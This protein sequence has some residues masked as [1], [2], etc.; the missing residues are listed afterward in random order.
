M[1][2]KGPDRIQVH[3][4]DRRR[5]RPNLAHIMNWINIHTDTL[6]S[7]DYLGA[8]PVERAT[9]LNLIG[10]CCSQEN[11]G[12]IENAADWSDRKW[13]QLCGV[14]KE[15]ATLVSALYQLGTNGDLVVSLYPISK[16][17]EVIAKR[18]TAKLNGAK[19]GRPPKETKKEPTPVIL[20]NP[21]H[22]PNVT[23]GESGREGKGREE[24]G[25]EGISC[26][27][28]DAEKS[29]L[30]EFWKQCPAQSRTRSTKRKVSDAWKRI[31]QGQRPD[32]ETF[33]GAIKQ[34]S[35]SED[36]TKD[37]GQF[38]PGAH[39]FI[40]DRRWEDLPET[41]GKNS[42]NSIAAFAAQHRNK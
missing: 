22:N 29:L 33:I 41:A 28:T 37:G 14:T 31:P 32:R 12:V 30:A 26:P 7:E 2:S 10:W 21:D 8:E 25:K 16:E 5:K 27:Q 3:M 40:K 15:E 17:Q 6:R 4:Q 34:W 39:L 20:E 36:W 23:Q 13:Q 42:E 38:A 24:K 11:G 1:Q 19:G 9:W 35:N 18:K